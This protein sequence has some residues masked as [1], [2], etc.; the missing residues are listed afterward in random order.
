TKRPMKPDNEKYDNPIV[1]LTGPDCISACDF[2][3]AF[4]DKFPEFT[5]I[6]MDNNGSFTGVSPREY[7][8]GDYD[9]VFEYIPLQAGAYVED[10]STDEEGKESFE[11]LLRRSDFLDEHIWHTKGSVMKGEDIVRDRAI[12]II[13]NAE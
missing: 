7:V 8:L 3:V 12:E 4:F 13:Q 10:I 5:I 11:L 1:I 6:G 2:L 9:S